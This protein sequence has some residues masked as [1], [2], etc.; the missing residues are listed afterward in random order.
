MRTILVPTD[1]SPPS[2]KALE[3]ARALATQFRATL[4]LIH[5]FDVQFEPPTRLAHFAT[6]AQIERGLRRRLHSVAAEVAPAIRKAHAHVRIGKPFQEVAKA[7]ARLNAD[8]IVI[9]THGYTGLKHAL[10]GSTAERIV[11]HAPCPV[12]V[13]RENEREF[14]A[15]RRTAT[16]ADGARLRLAHIVVPT[17]FSENSR[18]A[19][20]YAIA[21]AK[22]FGAKLTLLNAIY[23]Q[24][25]ATNADYL[26]FDYA[27]LI[28]DTRTWAKT[29]MDELIRTTS[30]QGVSFNTRIDDGH[31]VQNIVDFAAKGGAD[32]IVTSTHGRTGLK[33]VLIGSTAEQVVRHAKCPV[34]VVPRSQSK[35]RSRGR[36]K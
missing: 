23:P 8:L 29:E 31:P 25:Y 11:R 13:V 27:E 21:L 18:D 14:V 28:G 30:F 2:L 35:R 9:A 10:L 6:D 15:P 34:L 19:L 3:Y 24:Y 32:L 26:P 16:K 12:L 4:H 36:G 17:D 1:F 33:H 5:V 7:A 20:A 22:R